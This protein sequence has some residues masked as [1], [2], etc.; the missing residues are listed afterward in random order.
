MYTEALR[1]A[2]QHVDPKGQL[3]MG[4]PFD[5]GSFGYQRHSKNAHAI[6]AFAQ[7]AG[8]VPGRVG[9]DT[10]RRLLK[11]FED[12]RVSTPDGCC[13]KRSAGDE[14]SRA[15]VVASS[16]CVLALQ[17]LVKL[18]D[19]KINEVVFE[20]LN[21]RTPADFDRIKTPRL[22]SLM[23]CDV[24][25]SS[26][27]WGT[28][29]SSGVTQHLEYLRAQLLSKRTAAL[30]T[31]HSLTS[32][33][34][35]G[36]PGTGKTTY[37]ES[38]ASSTRVPLV[39]VTPSDLV[40][41]G[42]EPVERQ[43]TAVMRAL[44]MLTSCVILFD[45][46][47]SILYTR[48]LSSK[49]P[50]SIFEFLTAGMLPKLVNLSRSARENRSAYVLA[51]NYIERLDAAATRTGRFDVKRSVYYPDAPS[52]ACRLAS[53]I[54]RFMARNPKWQPEPGLGKRMARSVLMTAQVAPADLCRR[55]WFNAPTSLAELRSHPLWIYLDGKGPRH[56]SPP[57]PTWPMPRAAHDTL[58]R[59]D[60][61]SA[62]L[63]DNQ[64]A[65]EMKMIQRIVG[66]W[67]GLL[68]REAEAGRDGWT[69]LLAVTASESPEV[70]Q[71]AN[72]LREDLEQLRR[73]RVDPRKEKRRSVRDVTV[74]VKGQMARLVN[75]SHS[76]LCL[77]VD[78][79]SRDNLD[80]GF[81]VS[82]P[83]ATSVA[84]RFVWRDDCDSADRYLCGA[85]VAGTPLELQAWSRF[86]DAVPMLPTARLS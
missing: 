29:E 31:G 83:E 58:G 48:D 27:S 80:Q 79:L 70:V 22:D 34:V 60:G 26:T 68:A 62:R 2:T 33:I 77:E 76:G 74:L 63:S 6:K 13:W 1:V 14:S 72:R 49:P 5:I 36:P 69:D 81:E 11:Y 39:T 43:T 17:R 66:H 51:T 71:M 65:L 61:T 4:P 84:V 35:Y 38:L 46:F 52:R 40:M 53:E 73:D 32:L 45:E 15:S 54:V 19:A 30:H 67:D 9:S 59:E 78:G 47:D 86:V 82:L 8:H 75:V 37:V 44:S 57:E 23:S 7:I 24:G 64:L 55:G 25:V 3:P 20:H 12:T 85:E 16:L 42:A 50:A 21:V 41:Q 10:A 56:S 28:E 18:L